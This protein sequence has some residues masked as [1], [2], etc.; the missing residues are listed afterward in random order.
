MLKAVRSGKRAAQR[1]RALRERA[2]MSFFI[3]V[4]FFA[5][6]GVIVLTEILLIDERGRG[7]GVGLSGGRH[8]GGRLH[9][10]ADRPDYEDNRG[11]LQVRYD[12]SSKI[13]SNFYL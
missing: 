7:G 2:N 1:S 8:A 3:V 4:M 10:I 9:G 13:F 6:F 5:V 12:T 11:P